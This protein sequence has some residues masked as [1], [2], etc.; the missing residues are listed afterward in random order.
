MPEVMTPQ[1][2]QELL[3]ISSS[4]FF[5][6]VKAGQLP[7]AVKIGDSW[8]VLRDQLKDH[9]DQ[10]ARL[11]RQATPHGRSGNRALSKAESISDALQEYLQK[12]RMEYLKAPAAGALLEQWGLLAD[13]RQRPGKPL[14][15]LLRA[16]VIT[17]QEQPGRRFGLSPRRG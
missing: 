1:Q 9:L 2:V 5:R 8:R 17:G 10:T 14:R 3:Q 11:P 15:D 16:G 13:S 6:W 4:T 7:G 12:N